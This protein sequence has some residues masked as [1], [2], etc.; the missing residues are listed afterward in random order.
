MNP[1]DI[2]EKIETILSLSVFQKTSD[3][4][5]LTVSFA[6]PDNTGLKETEMS[7]TQVAIDVN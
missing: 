1:K 5:N 2:E 4:V 3:K 6:G 7:H